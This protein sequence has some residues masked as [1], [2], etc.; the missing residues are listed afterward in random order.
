LDDETLHAFSNLAITT[1]SQNS[2]FSNLIP[3]AKYD[4]WEE[5]F[6]RQSLKLQWMAKITDSNG[7]DKEQIDRMTIEI[8][9]L[10]SDFINTHQKGW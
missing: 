7:W 10:V 3:A 6:N 8:E 2:K 4:Q 5:I 1:G 9:E